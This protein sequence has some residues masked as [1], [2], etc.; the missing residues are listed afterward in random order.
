ML[1]ETDA[2]GARIFSERV[3]GELEAYGWTLRPVRVSLGVSTL[4]PTTPDA[5]GFVE[6]A[7]QAMYH[8]KRNGRN[9]VTHYQDLFAAGEDHGPPM[10][11]APADGPA[12]RGMSSS[13]RDDDSRVD[14]RQTSMPDDAYA[15]ASTCRETAWDVMD[16][17][18]KEM[19]DEK[20]ESEHVP[21]ALGAI[22]DATGADVAFLYSNPSREVAEI[23]SGLE[24]APQWCKEMA[25]R[26]LI[27][28]PEGGIARRSDLILRR[29]R[30]QAPAPESI[31]VA[32]VDD[33]RANWVIALSY[34]KARPLQLSDLKLISVSLA[35]PARVWPARQ[36]PGPL[37]R[38]PLRRRPLP[39]DG[40]RRQGSVH[41][42]P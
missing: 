41:L 4:G 37:A 6:E 38:D 36:R 12:V 5:D 17:L 16:R 8:A 21:A 29:D 20:G 19:K 22:C 1:P 33:Q 26:L 30:S 15:N 23:V 27:D 40:D 25:Q 39:L 11:S 28:H 42:R 18:L 9:R 34:N 13:A 7:D 31:A 35:A 10:P 2:D 32:P 3:R 24:V 14:P